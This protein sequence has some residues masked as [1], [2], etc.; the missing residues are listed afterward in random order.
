MAI[1]AVYQGIAE[2]PLEFIDK[3]FSRVKVKGDIL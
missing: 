3:K 2:Y 1:Y